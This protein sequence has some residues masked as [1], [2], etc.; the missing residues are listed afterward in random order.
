MFTT[1]HVLI[2]SV[3]SRIIYILLA[4]GSDTTFE[5]FDKSAV[6]LGGSSYFKFLLRWDALYFYEIIQKGYCKEHLMA[7]QPLFPQIVKTMSKITNTDPVSTA[8]YLNNFLFVMSSY[9]LYKITN[10]K[11]GPDI[12]KYTVLFF[13]FN[14][15]SIIYSSLYSESLYTFLFLL[16]YKFLESNNKKTAALVISLTTITRSNG[17]LNSILLFNQKS[18][19]ASILFMTSSTLPF[20]ILQSHQYKLLNLDSYTFPYG[21]IQK[22]YWEHGFLKFY[23]YKK[24][25][26]N[27]II[28]LPFILFTLYCLI[29]FAHSK[30]YVKNK[31]T[32]KFFT[33][34]QNYPIVALFILLSIQTL[35]CIFFIHMQMFFRFISYNPLF[36]WFMAFMCKNDKGFFRVIMFG[37]FYYGIA[38]AIL[39]GAYYPPA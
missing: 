29:S 12:A 2:L 32:M 26:P 10:R 33:N 3:A 39:F 8:V 18:L 14:P 15:S 37:Y 6:L 13:L 5:K 23:T 21:Y 25:I 9:L 36:Y 35:M 19:T 27:I 34:R 4:Y 22:K 30:C 24:N 7:F 20:L 31:L 38:Y 28:G 17:I 1:R 11:Y 16:G